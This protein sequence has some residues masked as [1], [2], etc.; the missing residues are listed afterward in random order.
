MKFLCKLHQVVEQLGRR[1]KGLHRNLDSHRNLAIKASFSLHCIRHRINIQVRSNASNILIRKSRIPFLAYLGCLCV[2]LGSIVGFWVHHW[3]RL[4]NHENHC[5][6]KAIISLLFCINL[7]SERNYELG[8]S[9]TKKQSE[10]RGFIFFSG[11]FEEK[12]LGEFENRHMTSRVSDFS[13]Y[14]E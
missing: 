1:V 5:I 10:E 9:G 3:L 11:N 4:L 14:K 7:V 8:K 13:I 12:A 6:T 2:C